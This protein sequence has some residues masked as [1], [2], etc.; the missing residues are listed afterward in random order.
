MHWP[1]EG[2]SWDPGYG[3]CNPPVFGSVAVWLQCITPVPSRWR[4]TK[5]ESGVW[6][7][8][9]H[10]IH[11][12][13]SGWLVS[14]RQSTMQVIFKILYFVHYGW[15]IFESVISTLFIDDRHWHGSITLLLGAFPNCLW[16]S[17]LPLT[18]LFRRLKKFWYHF[19][20]NHRTKKVVDIGEQPR[21]RKS[22]T[23]RVSNHDIR[24]FH[25]ASAR[26]Q[27]NIDGHIKAATGGSEGCTVSVY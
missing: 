21:K 12:G 11:P 20:C 25:S 14:R 9:Q 1:F 17:Y 10:Q 8:K 5:I 6:R 15:Q 16:R 4:P 27:Q 19:H 18:R 2:I 22:L 23:H 13:Q 3:C 7:C 24:Y 26:I